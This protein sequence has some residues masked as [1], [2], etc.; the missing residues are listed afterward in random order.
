MV[1]FNSYELL[2][3]SNNIAL[4]FNK[5]LIYDQMVLIVRIRLRFVHFFNCSS[6]SL[7]FFQSIQEFLSL[8][9]PSADEPSVL[10]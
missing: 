2:C 1:Y 8:K 9:S 3:E 6:H 5:S 7:S 4:K 10:R